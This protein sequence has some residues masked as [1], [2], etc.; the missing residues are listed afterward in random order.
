MDGDG[1]LGEA[2]RRMQT[3][4]TERARLEA[5]RAENERRKLKQQ[6]A[7]NEPHLARL[8][9]AAIAF[10]DRA[11]KARLPP[12]KITWDQ[13]ITVFAWRIHRI[14]RVKA[15]ELRPYCVGTEY[16]DRQS[17]RYV[18]VAGEVLIGDAR[19]LGANRYSASDMTRVEVKDVSQMEVDDLIDKMARHLAGAAS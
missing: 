6:L 9:A 2:V 17:G 14:R 16:Q 11:R 19:Y 3:E 1:G 4:A 18:T 10:A 12:I 7:A 5:E 15:W 8:N 13:W